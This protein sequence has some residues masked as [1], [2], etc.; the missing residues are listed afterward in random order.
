M[1]LIYG[2]YKIYKESIFIIVLFVRVGRKTWFW[3]VE[4]GASQ[5][6]HKWRNE[7]AHRKDPDF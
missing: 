7:S 5:R 1:T 3:E 6:D 4:F 2:C